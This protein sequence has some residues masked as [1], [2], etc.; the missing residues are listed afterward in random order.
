MLLTLSF[1]AKM[2]W[3]N[4]IILRPG[5]FACK[6]IKKSVKSDS[7]KGKPKG[8]TFAF[9]AFHSYIPLMSIYEFLT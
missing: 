1:H 2:P 9:S 7:G 5:V 8:R 3:S 4:T 6:I